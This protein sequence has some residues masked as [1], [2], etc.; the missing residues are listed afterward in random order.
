LPA[1]AS[2]RY[3][4][5]VQF[6]I[7]PGSAL[8]QAAFYGLAALIV[9]ATGLLLKRAA[10][11]V[12]DSPQQAASLQRRYYSG[13]SIWLVVVS[14]AAYSGALVPRGGP[15]LPFVILLVSILVLGVAVAR[16][17][18][19]DRLARGLP[20]AVLVGF[21]GFR[22]PL[23]LAMHRAHSEGLMPVQ[24]S[25]SGRNFDILTGLTA[26]ALAAALAGHPVPRW[27]V[28][29]WN[30][31]GLLLLA[32]ILAVAV[33]STPLFAYFGPDRLNVFVTW[34][35]YTLLPAVMVLAAWAGHLIIFR[36]LSFRAA[37]TPDLR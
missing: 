32:N 11:H 30:V 8:L 13:A 17:R 5:T 2:D 27:I 29:I 35:P 6:S 15:P 20:L 4:I 24:M 31:L 33:A 10:H 37:S 16:S 26:I 1:P 12:G 28:Q 19:G 7:L 9:I 18:V 36:A 22:F 25:Y 3:D 34:M 21:Q 23:E 14:A